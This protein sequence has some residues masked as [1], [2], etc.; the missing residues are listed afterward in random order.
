MVGSW[1]CPRGAATDAPIN[2][3]GLGM[4][5]CQIPPNFEAGFYNLSELT[6]QGW[7][8]RSP[9]L[10][11]TAFVNQTTLA[12]DVMVQPIVTAVSSNAGGAGGYDSIAIT[13]SSG[14]KDVSKYEVTASGVKC[15][16]LTVAGSVL[17][18]IT[19]PSPTTGFTNGKILNSTA[20]QTDPYIAGAGAKFTRYDIS[21]LST[22]TVAGLRA[23]LAGSPTSTVITTGVTTN[24]LE[25]DIPAN[26]ATVIKGYFKAPRTGDLKITASTNGKMALYIN[27]AYGTATVTYATAFVEVTDGS[28]NPNATSSTINIQNVDFYYYFELYHL[29]GTTNGGYV[30][31]SADI[32]GTL[33]EPVTSYLMRVPAT[34][35]QVNVVINGVLAICGATN[36]GYTLTEP[37]LLVT[38]TTY[39]ESTS[40]LRIVTTDSAT[41]PVVVALSNIVLYVGDLTIPCSGG[42][43]TY[44]DFTIVITQNQDSTAH[45]SKGT[46]AVAVKFGTKYARVSSTAIFSVTMALTAVT[47]TSTADSGGLPLILKGRGFPE[48]LDVSGFSV[49]YCGKNAQITAT[50]SGRVTI[51]TPP[52]STATTTATVTFNGTT[53]SASPA[54]TITT[55]TK[56]VITTIS[57]TGFSPVSYGTLT[58]TGTGFSSTAADCRLFLTNGTERRRIK[59][60]TRVSATTTEGVFTFD[61]GVAPGNYTVSF[62]N[63][64]VATSTEDKVLR[65]ETYISSLST[66]TLSPY[67][68]NSLVITGANFAPDIRDHKIIYK[69]GDLTSA[70]ISREGNCTI[71]AK[72]STTITCTSKLAMGALLNLDATYNVFVVVQNRYV[73]TSQCTGGACTVTFPADKTPKTNIGSAIKVTSGATYTITGSGFKDSANPSTSPQ[74]WIG[75]TQATVSAFDANNINITWPTL[76][77]GSYP[78]YVVGPFGSGR[79]SLWNTVYPFVVNNVSV[80]SGALYGG[81]TC[82]NGQGLRQ[83]T[84]TNVSLTVTGPTVITSRQYNYSA[85]GN[86]ICV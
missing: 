42:T 21:S 38:A 11:S 41:T 15:D 58:I 30:T 45:L 74:V 86:Q 83:S 16:S 31:L 60:L 35:P 46:Y 22:K 61:G 32:S 39:V 59:E 5:S 66:T 13:V 3:N 72:T 6:Y 57:P 69:V 19:S 25:T 1:E 67:G 53:T 12:Y 55:A 52:C 47:P 27:S 33:F 85:D 36:C 29:S 77:S 62:L 65:I 63:N 44:T 56:P 28:A 4:V 20:T 54:I 43:G 75:S 51:I 80:T 50:E 49:S 84:A 14:V 18:C 7:A 81:I 2:P 17:T 68:G 70:D 34:N 79:S 76:S 48:S 24:I 37:N 26:I 10:S 71:T 40:T 73:A 9:L 78:S 82:F 64:E 23:D 8:Q